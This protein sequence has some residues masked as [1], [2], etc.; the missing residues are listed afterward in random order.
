MELGEG[1]KKLLLAGI[2]TAAVLATDLVF[3]M[4]L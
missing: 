2:G 1:I 4:L 3:N